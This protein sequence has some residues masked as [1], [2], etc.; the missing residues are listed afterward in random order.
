MATIPAAE[1]RYDLCD[2]AFYDDPYDAYAW[3]R[4]NAP[5]FWDDGNQLW[6][7]SRY[8]D[9]VFAEKNP[10]LFSSAVAFRPWQGGAPRGDDGARLAEFATDPRMA[11]LGGPAR[12]KM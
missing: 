8:A 1:A 10:Q 11:V 4:E 12:R 2:H 6:A 5:V 9:V 3:M 7:L